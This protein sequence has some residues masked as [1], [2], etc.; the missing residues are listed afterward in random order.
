[1]WS[2]CVQAWLLDDHVPLSAV[3]DRTRGCTGIAA[4]V[5]MSAALSTMLWR[6][7]SCYA[8]F[9]SQLSCSQRADY[10]GMGKKAKEEH[11]QSQLALLLH[12]AGNGCAG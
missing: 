5:G 12:E 3:K 7:C 6:A 4:G 11:D 1:M 10:K 8:A 2:S 9:P